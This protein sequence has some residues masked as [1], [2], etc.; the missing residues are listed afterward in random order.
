MTRDQ[1]G[2]EL[3]DYSHREEGREGQSSS[4]QRN[5]GALEARKGSGAEES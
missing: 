3:E 2:K 1:Q 5:P 4:R